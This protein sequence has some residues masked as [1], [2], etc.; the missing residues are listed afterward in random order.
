MMKKERTKKSCNICEKLQRYD[1]FGQSVTLHLDQGNDTLSS[2]M[3]ALCSL[4]LLILVLAYSCY[5]VYILQAKK[6]I[7]IV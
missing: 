1:Q 2:K 5:K 7:D 4:V 3:G 6:S